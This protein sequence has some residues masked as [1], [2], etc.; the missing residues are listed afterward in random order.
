MNAKHQKMLIGAAMVAITVPA[1]GF[2]ARDAFTGNGTGIGIGQFRMFGSGSGTETRGHGMYGEG[3][4]GMMKNRE[5]AGMG[6]MRGEGMRGM[7]GGAKIL[8]HEKVREA[9]AASGVTLPSVEAI[10]AFEAKMKA[11]R[12]AESKLS[13]ADKAELKKMRDATMAQVKAVHEAAAKSERDYLRS[14][15]VTL[16]TEDEIAKMR[17]LGQKAFDTLRTTMPQFGGKNGN[18][19]GKNGKNR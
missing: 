12:D 18:R 16:P 15:G 1:M 9:L 7:G 13:D 17:D 8:S 5:G 3:M 11:A 6:P 4:R 2:A 14:K 10:D 19:G